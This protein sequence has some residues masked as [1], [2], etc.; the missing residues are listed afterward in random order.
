L[1]VEGLVVGHLPVLGSAWITQYAKHVAEARREAVAL[2][3]MQEGQTWLDVVMP[4]SLQAR[5]HSRVGPAAADPEQCTLDQAIGRAAREARVWLVRVDE[6]AEPDLPSIPG[7]ASITLLT[8]ADDAAVV[9]S[10]RTIKNLRRVV[11]CPRDDGRGDAEDGGAPGEPAD[12]LGEDDEGGPQR[13]LALRLAIMGADDAKAADAE[14]K[15]RRAAETFLGESLAPAAKVAKIGGSSTIALYRGTSTMP[16]R[17][18]IGLARAERSPEGARREAVPHADARTAPAAADRAGPATS[19]DISGD[20]VHA[21]GLG[22]S[23]PL[24][25][26]SRGVVEVTGAPIPNGAIGPTPTETAD[27]ASLIAG[28]R[29]LGVQ[30]PYATNVQIAT[31]EDGALHLLVRAAGGQG[32][33]GDRVQELLAAASWAEDHRDL[34]A[35]VHPDLARAAGEAGPHLHLLTEDA[36]HVRGLIDTAI[37]LHVLCHVGV[38]GRA[39]TVAKAIN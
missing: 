29:P 35:R 12:G 32:R 33:G 11:A 8:G 9:A 16:V 10:Y 39:I 38:N 2:L 31:G 22:V 14:A 15:L 34:L 17:E 30:C 6:T 26:M 23:S 18:V 4:R 36:R 20:V 7:L 28:L 13:G 19:A 1:C 25:H 27:L 24:D 21:I 5:T 3:R 37:R